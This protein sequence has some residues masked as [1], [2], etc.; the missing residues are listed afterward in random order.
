MPFFDPTTEPAA[1]PKGRFFDDDTETAPPM[2]SRTE[3]FLKGARKGAESVN[4]GVAQGVNALTG[5]KLLNQD[6]LQEMEGERRAESTKI[7]E[8]RGG[9][10]GLTNLGSIGEFAGETLPGMAIPATRAA[11]GV[12]SLG[13]AAKIGAIGGGISGASQP[14]VEGESRAAHTALGVGAGAVLGAAGTAALSGVEKGI[15][16]IAG[17]IKEPTKYYDK[18]IEDKLRKVAPETPGRYKTVPAKQKATENRVQAVKDIAALRDEVELVDP[19]TN[20]QVKGITPSSQ[21]DLLQATHQGMQKVM[22]W[23][24]EVA[25]AMQDSGRRFAP[26]N[27]INELQK[28]SLQGG[29]TRE[30]V[31]TA[32]KLIADLTEATEGEGFSASAALRRL[33]GLN[34][35]IKSIYTG[36]NKSGDSPEVIALAANHYRKQFNDFMSE[37]GENYGELRK[38]WGRLSA[39]DEDILRNLESRANSEA[40]GGMSVFDILGAQQI[41]Q[42]VT[43]GRP[44]KIGSGLLNIIGVDK[45]LKYFTGPDKAVRDMFKVADKVNKGARIT[46]PE[47]TKPPVQPAAPPPP[48]I[49][50]GAALNDAATALAVDAEI[51]KA[52]A[53]KFITGSP[54]TKAALIRKYPSLEGL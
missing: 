15:S 17:R 54:A 7:K 13:Q 3:Q 20:L 30:Q 50:K 10:A 19:N 51:P 49:P 11:R 14:L 6:I 4:L 48:V 24:D 27:A 18:L 52:M 41:L 46:K 22:S 31:G 21:D 29:Y 23:T 42:G 39:V 40:R 36:Q 12:T 37:A 1:S 26:S 34:N 8:A 33:T 35:D 32:Q 2:M 44:E 45:A 9:E 43:M 16:K 47:I 38:L 5:G 53:K 25:D 28:V